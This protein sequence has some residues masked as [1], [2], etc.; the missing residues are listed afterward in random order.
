MM[1]DLN[2]LLL[3][4]GFVIGTLSVFLPAKIWLRDDER[5]SLDAFKKQVPEKKWV[6]IF[7]QILPF[8]WLAIYAVIIFPNYLN[9]FGLGYKQVYFLAYFAIAGIGLGDGILEIVTKVSPIRTYMGRSIQL[10]NVV[11]SKSI[12]HFGLVHM[13]YILG[14][15]G[16]SWLIIE[17]MVMIQQG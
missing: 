13:S 4:S 15:G 9:W 7:F 3:V 14:V 1:Q 11:Y 2:P 6:P 16:I 8:V 10:K 17:L 5:I 12:R